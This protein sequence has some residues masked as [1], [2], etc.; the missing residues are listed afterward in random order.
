MNRDEVVAQFPAL[1]PLAVKWA[2]E[3]ERVILEDGVALTPEE[4]EDALAVGVE[5]PNRVRLLAVDRKSVV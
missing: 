4:L 3:Q 2:V 1:L 5:Q